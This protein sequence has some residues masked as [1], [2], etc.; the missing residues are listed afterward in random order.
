MAKILPGP[1]A[2]KISGTIG[3]T[4]YGNWRG[5]IVARTKPVPSKDLT[6][7]Q[8]R[9][10]ALM[11]ILSI[12]WRD[13]LNQ[14]LR[15]AWNQ[16]SKNYPWTDVFGNQRKMTGE[17]LYIK[18][19]MILLDFGLSRNDQPQPETVPPDCDDIIVN[20]SIID[21]TLTIEPLA[22]AIVT[23]QTPFV[24][25]M[26]AGGFLSIDVGGGGDSINIDTV[27]LPPGRIAGK[28]DFRHVYYV[29][30]QQTTLGSPVEVVIR[31]FPGVAK[32]ITAIV[33]RYNKYGNFSA[34]RKIVINPA[35]REI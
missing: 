20:D 6:I 4:T 7:R 30:A 2:A 12:A 28:S 24:N 5:M 11:S 17:N 34:P 29:P 35:T 31:S 1:L 32:N 16:M 19:N 15:T 22:D 3:G 33:Q 26:V 21:M 14:G 18:Q 13:E 9:I 23:S 27:G 8:M 25:I 10:N